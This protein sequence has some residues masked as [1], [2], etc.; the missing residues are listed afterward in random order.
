MACYLRI[1]AYLGPFW[2]SLKGPVLPSFGAYFSALNLAPFWLPEHPPTNGVE[3][4]NRAVLGRFGPFWA[5]LRDPLNDLFWCLFCALDLACFGA[6]WRTPQMAVLGRFGRFRPFL[7]PLPHV[8]CP[9]L[10]PFLTPFWPLLGGFS[11][12]WTL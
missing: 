9:L 4:S 10:T 12:L 5:L 1:W 2:G 7:G 3:L 8:I 11:H 6:V